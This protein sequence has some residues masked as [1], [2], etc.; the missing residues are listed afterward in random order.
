LVVCQAPMIAPTPTRDSRCRNRRI[1]SH[2]HS[3]M[4][5]L[6]LEGLG[7]PRSGIGG[8]SDPPRW[9]SHTCDIV[10]SCNWV[11]SRDDH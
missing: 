11:R 9:L 2:V 1:C 6:G 3:N 5:D 8:P 7:V 10:V 4:D